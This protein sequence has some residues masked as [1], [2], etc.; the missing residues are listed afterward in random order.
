MRFLLSSEEEQKP[1]KA[2]HSVF[3]YSL[4]KSHCRAKFYLQ[5]ATLS[6]FLTLS[7]LLIWQY[8]RLLPERKYIL[9]I[10]SSRQNNA[11]TSGNIFPSMTIQSLLRLLKDIFF[12]SRIKAILFRRTSCGSPKG[13]QIFSGKDQILRIFG[14]VDSMASVITTQFCHCIVNAVNEWAFLFPSK[15]LL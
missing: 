10:D 4:N 11:W 8:D 6:V 15:T 1:M 2:S 12:C 13:L 9:R 5:F 7:S 3:K 14:F